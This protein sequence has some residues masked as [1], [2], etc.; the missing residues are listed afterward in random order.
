[1]VSPLRHSQ[2]FYSAQATPCPYL[3]GKTE[4]KI[5]ADLATPQANA[6]HSRLSRAGFRRSH[7]F[8]YMPMCEN[9][10]ACIPI[11][12]PVSQFTP[13]RTQRRTLR[14]NADLVVSVATPVATAEQ[15]ALFRRYQHSRHADSDMAQMTETDYQGMIEDTPVATA[16]LEFRTADRTLVAVSLIDVLEDGISAVYNFYDPEQTQRSLGSF[17]IL[18]LTEHTRTLNLPYLY[19]GY[20]IEKSEKMAY[21]TNYRPAE[22]LQSGSWRPLPPPADAKKT[23]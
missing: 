8:A 12:L 21:K 7:T 6:L 17:A 2:F 11:R 10:S 9:C 3:P 18:T 15:Y 14:R 19:L 4:R 20:W 23:F 1:M 13:D 16:V 22:I 5:I